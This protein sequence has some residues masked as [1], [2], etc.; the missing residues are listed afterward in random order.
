MPPATVEKKCG[1]CQITKPIDAFYVQRRRGRID[2]QARCKKCSNSRRWEQGRFKTQ[3]REAVYAQQRAY[4]AAHA[5]KVLDRA[6]RWRQ[7]AKEKAARRKVEALERCGSSICM[8]CGFNHPAALQF[9]HRDPST[10]LFNI[11]TKLARVNPDWSII[12]EELKKCDVLCSNCHDIE[13]NGRAY[14][15]WN[16]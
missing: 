10:K 14:L 13:H 4:Y 1:S 16:K 6:A 11:S 8:R 12:D 9:H 2:Y 15:W 3:S 7:T 5:E